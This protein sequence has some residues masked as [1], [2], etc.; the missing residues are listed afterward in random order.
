[1]FAARAAR[2]IGAILMASGRV[3]KTVTIRM[4]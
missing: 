1:M 3:P 2:M 4:N